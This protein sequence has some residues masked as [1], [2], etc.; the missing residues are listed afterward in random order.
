MDFKQVETEFK[1]LKAQYD[2]GALTENAFK[3][4]LEGLM[5]RDENGNWWMVGYETE[6]WRP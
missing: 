1:H 4:K 5:I 2:T 3:S 6:H